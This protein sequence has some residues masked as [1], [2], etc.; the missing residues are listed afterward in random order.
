MNRV[1]HLQHYAG[2][3][4][5]VVLLAALAALV[6]VRPAETTANIRLVKD[7]N[8]TMTTPPSNP[9]DLTAV[10]STLYFMADDGVTA[11][12]LWKTDGTVAGTMMVKQPILCG[13]CSPTSPYDFTALGSTLFFRAYDERHGSELWKTDGTA[14]STVMLKDINPTNVQ[15]DPVS[16]YFFPSYLTAAGSA[17]FFVTDDGVHG[18][19]LWTSDGTA[20][21]TSMVKD[22]WPGSDWGYPTSLTNVNGI[23][24]FVADDG[25]HGQELWKSDGTAAGTSMLKDIISNGSSELDRLT[26][27]G[28]TLYFVANDGVH[29]VELWTSDG[30]AAGTSMLKDVTPAGW[31]GSGPSDLTAVGST[32]YFVADDGVHGAE[33]WTSNGSVAGTT[34]VKDINPATTYYFPII[35]TTVGITEAGRICGSCPPPLPPPSRSIGSNPDRLTEVGNTLFLVA[36]D[37][38]HGRELWRSDGTKNGTTM[39]KDITPADLT[40]GE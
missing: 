8:T 19:E 2:W 22:I 9:S 18:A 35:L 24:Y 37:G 28:N 23:L 11:N 26:G 40:T 5:V 10:G 6:S 16:P 15:Y 1:N 4:Y 30:T 13:P 32:L 27:V 17:L 12:E 31:S 14:A 34:L 33:L 21:G 36:D 39:V 7:I 3:S 25:M 38:V 20:N 29:G